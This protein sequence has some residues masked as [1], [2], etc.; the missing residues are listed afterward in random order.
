MPTL[1]LK[2]YTSLDF[3]NTNLIQ[4]FQELQ[5]TFNCIFKFDT[6]NQKIDIVEMDPTKIGQNQGL[7]ISNGNFI[8]S[9]SKNIKYDEVKTRLFVYGKDNVSIQSISPTGQPFLDNFDAFKN[10]KFMTQG[11]ID[12]L[13]AYK[14]KVENYNPNFEPLLTQLQQA[15]QVMEDLINADHP[16]DLNLKGLVALERALSIVQTQIDVKVEELAI[17]KKSIESATGTDLEDM[18]ADMR[19]IQSAIEMYDNEKANI[20]I[21][22]RKNGLK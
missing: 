2:M 9:L 8:K 13:D 21:L 20:N 19:S 3:P 17:I 11:L 4:V 10:T 7:Y 15:N 14:T 6:I 22:I 5:E 12:A 18:Y 16:S 1:F